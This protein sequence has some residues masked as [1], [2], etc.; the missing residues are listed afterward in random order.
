[1]GAIAAD[2]ALAREM[3]RRLLASDSLRTSVIE[4]MLADDRA[5]QYLLAR[6]GRNEV[7]VDYVLQSA[8]SDSGGREHLMSLFKGMQIAL[9]K[10]K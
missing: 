4:T 2:S 1:M 10:K 5:A 8:A 3:T 7:A 6:I 9:Q